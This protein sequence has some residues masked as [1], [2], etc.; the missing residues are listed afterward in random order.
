MPSLIEA[1]LLSLSLFFFHFSWQQNRNR[2]LKML[3]SLAAS[4]MSAKKHHE[5]KLRA[6]PEKKNRKTMQI[7]L[8]LNTEIV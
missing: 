5:I 2:E 4:V 6:K 8:N 1:L 7:L 3:R